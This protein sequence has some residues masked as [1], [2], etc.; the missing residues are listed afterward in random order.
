[1]LDEHILHHIKRCREIEV[2]LH[3]AKLA[4]TSGNAGAQH[5]L[6]EAREEHKLV[7]EQ[8]VSAVKFY[9][10]NDEEPLRI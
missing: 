2:T 4:T 10:N 6:K 1:M 8:R 7:W 5:R 9:H 3:E